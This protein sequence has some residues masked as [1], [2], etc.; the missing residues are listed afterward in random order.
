MAENVSESEVNQKISCVEGTHGR[1]AKGCRC[2]TC[3]VA[4]RIY[5]RER[6][7]LKTKEAYGLI[8]IPSKKVDATEIR[9]HILFLSK[10]NIGVSYIHKK[11]GMSKSALVNIKRGRYP[12]VTIETANKILSIPAIAKADGQYVRSDEAKKMIAKM[13]KA[14]YKPTEIGRA[15]NGYSQSIKIQKYVRKYK[16]DKIKNVYDVLMSPQVLKARNK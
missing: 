6:K 5:T 12:N 10:N 9:E 13:F 11:T 4:H 16:H 8:I 3:T 15:Y 7:R 14:G 2:E 1:Y